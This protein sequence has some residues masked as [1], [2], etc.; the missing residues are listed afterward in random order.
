MMLCGGFEALF[1]DRIVVFGEL[2]C[3]AMARCIDLRGS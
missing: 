2:R 3:L 1:E